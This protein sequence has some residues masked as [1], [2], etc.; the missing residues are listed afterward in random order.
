MKLYIYFIQVILRQADSVC[1]TGE[2]R[3]QLA[4]TLYK[5]VLPHYHYLAK[6]FIKLKQ[7]FLSLIAFMAVAR[8][9]RKLIGKF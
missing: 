7:L 8:Q 2:I 5:S 1:R 3:L 4:K 6:F 9:K